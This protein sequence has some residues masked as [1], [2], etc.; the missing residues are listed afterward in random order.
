MSR[1][2]AL[3]EAVAR[4]AI[5]AIEKMD[6]NRAADFRR[7]LADDAVGVLLE[8]VNPSGDRSN[9]SAATDKREGGDA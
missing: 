3:L 2:V 7:R 6:A 5:T 8:Q 4:L 9:V 1:F